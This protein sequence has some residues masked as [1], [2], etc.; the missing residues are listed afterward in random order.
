MAAKRVAGNRRMTG[1]S[2]F[3]I[4]RLSAVHADVAEAGRTSVHW[5]RKVCRVGNFR[6][7]CGLAGM[8]SF[9]YT[10]YSLRCGRGKTGA[11]RTR[12]Q[13]RRRSRVTSRHVG[14]RGLGG[15]WR[16]GVRAF[17]CCCNTV[18]RSF[19]GVRGWTRFCWFRFRCAGLTCNSR[20]WRWTRT[21]RFTDGFHFLLNNLRSGQG[22]FGVF[23][24][25]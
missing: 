24:T 10:S 5:E 17:G 1:V 25:C 3:G 9:S 12:T 14:S 20:C 4:K 15:S 11:G 2:P 6:Q 18:T 13:T 8:G 22:L 19:G 7:T 16:R 23:R 21:S